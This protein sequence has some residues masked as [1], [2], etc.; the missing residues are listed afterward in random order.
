MALIKRRLKNRLSKLTTID[1]PAGFLAPRGRAPQQVH[2][3]EAHS[4]G[5]FLAEVKARIYSRPPMGEIGTAFVTGALA[6]G[7]D[8]TLFKSVDDN[9]GTI[10]EGAKL[11][12]CEGECD[13]A[14]LQQVGHI[15]VMPPTFDEL[16]RYLNVWVTSG[17]K[18]LVCLSPRDEFMLLR[19]FVDEI[20]SVGSP[21]I[22][23]RLIFARAP[24]EGWEKISE[25]LA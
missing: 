9:Q 14:V 25:L 12:E 10:P 6:T 8:V 23:E 11:M 13:A 16:E 15:W 18:P 20:V 19:G 17:Y 4:C 7:G 2:V 3:E 5:E 1:A 24:E 22:S 21:R